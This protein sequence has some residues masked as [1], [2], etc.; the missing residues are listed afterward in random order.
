VRFTG[1]G[2]HSGHPV[3]MTIHPADTGIAFRCNG[4]RVTAAP[5][6]VTGTWLRT[7]LGAVATVEHL[8]S[9]FAGMGI[10]DAE[11]ELSYPEL[12]A[13]DGSAARYVAALSVSPL[14]EAEIQLPPNETVLRTPDAAIKVKPGTGQ[15]SYTF[16][17]SSGAQTVTCRLP[18]DYPA[19]VAPARTVALAEQMSTQRLGLGLDM[20]SVV[21]LGPGGYENT[22]RFPDEPARH[23]LLDLIGDLYLTSIPPALLDVEATSSGHTTNIRMAEL[24]TVHSRSMN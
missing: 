14:P 7:T 6:C 4:S 19:E 17:H 20:S 1:L 8:M 2:L 9:A 11:V 5:G 3:E 15:W 18:R 24:L 12:P 21:I 22:P 13:L 10:T 23:K 16:R